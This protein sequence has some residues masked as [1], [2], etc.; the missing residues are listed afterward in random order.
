MWDFFTSKSPKTP[1]SCFSHSR[2]WTPLKIISALRDTA[3]KRA[4]RKATEYRYIKTKLQLS[5]SS[6]FPF[7]RNKRKYIMPS[8]LFILRS[9]SEQK[10]KS[11]SSRLPGFVKSCGWV[12][13]IRGIVVVTWTA[14]MY[15]FC[16]LTG[17]YQLENQARTPK[18]ISILRCFGLKKSQLLRPPSSRTNRIRGPEG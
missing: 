12:L 5:L 15:C 7:Y 9:V 3:K 8:A 10:E 18:V 2:V 6:G 4:E 13:A 16:Y 11:T 1:S 14:I 17:Y